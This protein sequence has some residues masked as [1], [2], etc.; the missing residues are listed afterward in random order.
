[1]KNRILSILLALLLLMPTVVSCSENTAEETGTSAQAAENV[2]DPSADPTSETAAET[3]ERL[4]P[5]IP[6]KADFGGDEICFVWWNIATWGAGTHDTRDLVVEELNGEAIN[7]AVYNRNLLIGQ[8]YNVKFTLEILPFDSIVKTVNSCVRSGD[9]SYDVVYPRLVEATP[10]YSD[11]SLVNIH[12]V[13]YIDLEKPWWDA[14]CADAM[15]VYGYLPAVAASINV[16]DKDATVCIGFNKDVVEIY[17]LDDL[18]TLVREGTWTLDN[19]TRLAGSV[20]NDTNGDGV[21][22]DGDMYGIYGLRDV[23]ESF[24]YGSGF[25][26]ATRIEDGGIAFT[27]GSEPEVDYTQK[28]MDMMQNDWFFNGHLDKSSLSSGNRFT[29]GEGLFLWM[30]L[31]DVTNMREL[32]GEFGIIPTPKANEQQENYYSMVSRHATGIMSIPTTQYG[33]KLEALGMILE[34]MAAESHYTVIPEYIETSLKTK[35]SRDAESG[36][37]M[38]IIISSR[39]YDPVYI[40]NFASFADEFLLMGQ[41]GYENV[42]SFLKAKEKMMKKTIEK[43]NKNIA[44]IL[45]NQGE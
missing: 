5:D 28:V 9:D 15:T 16:N 11:G 45:E 19:F 20:A 14:N 34:A 12:T 33:E 37:M 26:H 17:Q 43:F 40:F 42:A 23:M 31:G 24:Y 1:M 27:Y 10:L 30:K 35:Y 22:G 6:E 7:D 3:E 8:N 44:K 21:M 41:P 32:E 4:L 39:I 25:M 38:D 36:E 13:P 29:N 2:A 18:Y